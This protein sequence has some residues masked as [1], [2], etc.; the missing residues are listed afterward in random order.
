[1]KRSDSGPQIIS[2][3]ISSI[4]GIFNI[5]ISGSL[6]SSFYQL[7]PPESV[8][9]DCKI[10]KSELFDIGVTKLSH[11]ES[12]FYT[13]AIMFPAGG[14]GN[15]EPNKP[16]PNKKECPEKSQVVN[17][18]C[19]IPAG[20]G[21]KKPRKNENPPPKANP[22]RD[23]KFTLRLILKCTRRT[24]DPKRNKWVDK[25]KCHEKMDNY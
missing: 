8:K 6:A 7:T 23:P 12:D 16:D 22:G 5:F 25:K 19:T 18:P 1:M 9:S 15:D 2:R 10:D 4:K 11:R 20:C 3:L 17:R 13:I 14:G 21:K 24:L